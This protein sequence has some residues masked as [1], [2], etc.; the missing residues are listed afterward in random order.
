MIAAFA[1]LALRRCRFCLNHRSCRGIR[2]VIARLLA[3][4]S[5]SAMEGS[6]VSGGGLRTLGTPFA[7]TL[8]HGMAGNPAPGA[9]DSSEGFRSTQAGLGCRRLFFLRRRFF[10]SCLRD[11]SSASRSRAQATWRS[12]STMASVVRCSLQVPRMGRT[13]T[14]KIPVI[15]GIPMTSQPE[16]RLQ[17]ARISRR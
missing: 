12:D 9:S 3:S 1:R 2:G 10:R 8:V 11:A 7:T 13:G 4:I 14:R 5:A 16:A 6:V 15:C 17:E